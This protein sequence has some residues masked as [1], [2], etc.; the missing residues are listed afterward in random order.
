[1]TRRTS[2]LRSSLRR[3]SSTAPLKL[4]H[5]PAD[6]RIA[7]LSPSTKLDGLIEAERLPCGDAARPAPFHR[8]RSTASLKRDSRTCKGDTLGPFRRRSS[9]ASLKRFGAGAYGAA[10][11]PFRRRSSTASLKRDHAAE[12]L[13][14][15]VPFPSTK[16]DGL[17]EAAPRSRHRTGAALLSVDEA[18]RPH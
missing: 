13:D 14:V 15:A 5:D 3:R 12:L 18:R 6:L 7:L 2:A 4:D 8:R 16:L 17:I 1:M 10:V 11:W 9:T